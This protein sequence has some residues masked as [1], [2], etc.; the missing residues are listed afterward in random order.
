M[1]LD[2]IVVL[3]L[4]KLLEGG[5]AYWEKRQLPQDTQRCK[6]FWETQVFASHCTQE[7]VWPSN[8][9]CVIVPPFKLTCSI[10]L[11]DLEAVL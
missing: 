10:K 2:K 6:C 3:N 4:R 11:E 9:A 8:I 1:L 7:G 5:G